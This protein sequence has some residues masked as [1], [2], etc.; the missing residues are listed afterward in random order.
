MKH[1]IMFLGIFREYINYHQTTTNQFDK[2]SPVT[3]QGYY[4]KYLLVHE[5]L[6]EKN[7]QRMSG[8]NFKVSV[9]KEYF[10]YLMKEG[11]S[12]NYAARCVGIC[13]TVLD[14]GLRNEMIDYNPLSSYSIPKMPPKKP[15]YFTPNQIKLWENYRSHSHIKQKAADLFVLIMHTGFDYGDLFEVGRQHIVAHKGERYII[16]PRHK[17]GNDA[18]IPLTE[19]AEELLEKYDYRMK[20]LS[21]PELNAAIKE[22]A[23]EVGINIYLTA[24]AGRKIYMMNKLNNEGY[25]IE[26]VSK[27]GGHKSIK[28][29]EQTYAQ[30]NIELVHKEMVNRR[31]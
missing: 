31:N 10:N 28:T 1:Y 30:V 25:S 5:F 12:H 23:R 8:T 7:R 20:A 13:S 22:V 4:N 9:A 17:N 3:I 21:N 16:K 26:A 18:I 15:T 11:H 27:M 14:Y 2:R 24:K 19:K 6:S 29:T